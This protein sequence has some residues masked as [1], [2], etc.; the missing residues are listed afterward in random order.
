MNRNDFLRQFIEMRK[1]IAP[2]PQAMVDATP[3][4]K[5]AK[6]LSKTQAYVE[7]GIQEIIEKKPGKRHLEE[8]FQK[9][10]QE[11]DAAQMA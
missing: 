3:V 11:L 8:Y 1:S 4:S 2:T 5:K 9:M 10:C 7:G 6:K